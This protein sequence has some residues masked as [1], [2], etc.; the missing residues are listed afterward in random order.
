MTK[1]FEKAY[2]S[3]YKAYMNDTLAKGTCTACAVGNIIADAMGLVIT[4]LSPHEYKCEGFNTWWANIFIT[5]GNYQKIY[6]YPNL[7]DKKESI[8]ILTDYTWQEMAK[9]EYAFE[10]NTKINYENYYSS[11]D[12]AIL[13]DQFNGLMAVM[14]VMIELDEIAEGEKYKESFKN[15]FNHVQ[16]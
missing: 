4:K 7:E 9:I 16:I 14:D 8:K 1:R 2:N 10:T 12:S 11:S 13:N 3:L 5:L 15:K 6:S